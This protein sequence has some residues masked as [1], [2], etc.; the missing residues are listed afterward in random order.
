MFEFIQFVFNDHVTVDEVSR[1]MH[2]QLD[3][4]FEHK[5]REQAPVGSEKNE[6]I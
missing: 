4:L 5:L 2:K 3:F 1:R 6:H